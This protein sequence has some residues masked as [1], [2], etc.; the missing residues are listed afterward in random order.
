MVSSPK[1][2][3]LKTPRLLL[4]FTLCSFTTTWAQKNLEADSVRL[5]ND[6]IVKAYAADRPQ[7][8]VA[9]AISVIKEAD[10]NRFGN[11]SLVP[12]ANS[13]PGV[14]MEERSPGSYRFS[15]RGSTLRSPFGVRNVK[16]YWNGL[17]LT[18]GS[19]NTY[20]NLLDF[21]AIGN[22]EIIKGPGASLYGAG[23]GGVV[24][25][26]APVKSAFSV[27]YVAGSYG[28][29]KIQGGGTLLASKKFQLDLRLASQRVD[30]YRQQSHMSR[31]SAQ[32]DWRWSITSK[33]F[34]TG[35]V[36]STDLSYETPG[37][38]TEAQYDQ[39]ARQARPD[40]SP[41]SPGAV[42]Q[43][44]AVNNRTSYIGL[45]FDHQWSERW[46]SRAGMFGSVT[47][48]KNPTIRNYEIREE[49][50][51]GGRTDTQYKFEQSSWKGKLAFGAEYQHFNSPITD[52]DNLSGVQGSVQTDDVLQSQLFL[53][54]AQVEFDLPHDI[55]VTVGGSANFVNY[56]FLRKSSTPQ[57]SQDRNFDPVI[58]PR[59]ALL[60]KISPVLSAYASVSSG[61]SPPSLAEVRP[62]T[63][64]FNNTLNAERGTSY[65][66]GTKGR[67]LN[68]LDFSLAVYDFR[69]KD[70]IVI[71][72]DA[73]GADYFVNAGS[74]SQQGVEV[75]TSWQTSLTSGLNTLRFWM[76]YTYNHFRF[77]QYVN[78]GNNYS[79]KALTGVSPTLASFGVDL[80]IKKK[81]FVNMTGNYS[82]RLPLNDANTDYASDYFLLGTK[83]GYKAIISLPVEIFAGVDNALDKKYSLGNDL[84]AVGGRYYNVAIGR[85]F[86]AGI[87]VKLGA[88]PLN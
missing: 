1:I 15:I 80:T 88:A 51:W 12:A 38:L 19:G 39:D 47:H 6:V 2:L 40:A 9:A 48:F 16:F 22:M 44:A 25:L 75:Y 53:G 86:Y 43:Q 5:L 7:T 33:S 67:L 72:R 27:Q 36:L 13:V 70:A 68:T 31:E 30:G 85:N 71:Q 41:T 20:L 83:V 54:F 3:T 69:L 35:T 23:T 21:N 65:E 73:T 26:K 66:V 57:V 46:S 45:S 76:S 81:F 62:S 84:N 52:Y 77:D 32:L 74:T 34:L 82:E 17:P 64:T 8:E 79:G 28:L 59:V 4:L 37:G 24:L 18:D 49:E 11:I 50:N 78:D 29:S 14:R 87:I 60:K 56:N 55:F 10:L 61:F 42:K 58:S 63:A